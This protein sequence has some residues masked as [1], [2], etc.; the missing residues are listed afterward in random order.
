MAHKS[1]SVVPHGFRQPVA[2]P[3]PS[4]AACEVAFRESSTGIA[5]IGRA[6]PQA[7]AIAPG[8]EIRG[9]LQNSQEQTVTPHRKDFRMNF[10]S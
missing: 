8:C 10:L 7:R 1:A 4:R 6:R 3:D 5:S 2:R 9:R